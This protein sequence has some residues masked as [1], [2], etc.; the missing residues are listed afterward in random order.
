MSTAA[1]STNLKTAKAAKRAERQGA[2]ASGKKSLQAESANQI[3]RN[4]IRIANMQPGCTAYRINNVGV[5][6]AAKG[7]HRAGN[8]EKGLPDIWLCVYGFFFTIEVKAGSD[9]MSVHQLMRKD[10]IERAGGDMFECQGTSH[11]IAWFNRLIAW[12]KANRVKRPDF[13]PI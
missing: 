2:T 13:K 10:E 11:F 12:A 1:K 6:D 7:I 5:W 4:I 9:R 8:T 3:T